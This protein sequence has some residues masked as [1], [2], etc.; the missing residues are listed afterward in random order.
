MFFKRAGRRIYLLI[1]ALSAFAA[2][3]S[4]KSKEQCDARLKQFEQRVEAA[5]VPAPWEN[6]VT[7]YDVPRVPRE[8]AR[9]FET[10]DALIIRTGYGSKRLGGVSGTGKI[11]GFRSASG[12]TL[13]ENIQR[14][15]REVSGRL[16]V[17]IA[18]PN[19]DHDLGDLDQLLRYVD[20]D[21]EFR[22]IV[23]IEGSE[24]P[25][26]PTDAPK[27]VKDRLMK[28]DGPFASERFS[29][30]QKTWE[31]ASERCPGLQ[32]TMKSTL[33]EPDPAAAVS[34]VIPALKQCECNTVDVPALEA[35]V[36]L[37]YFRGGEPELGWVPLE[38]DVVTGTVQDFVSSARRGGTPEAGL[39]GPC[40][41]D[42]DC[43]LPEG[44][45]L[46]FEPSGEV[47]RLGRLS[48]TRPC[49]DGCPTGYR[50]AREPFITGVNA[51]GQ[52]TGYVKEWCGRIQPRVSAT[53]L[54]EIPREV[55]LRYFAGNLSAASSFP[56]LFRGDDGLL[57]VAGS[58]QFQRFKR[59][60]DAYEALSLL[61][62]FN[63]LDGPRSARL[64][65]LLPLTL[66]MIEAAPRDLAP[67]HGMTLRHIVTTDGFEHFSPAG[68]FPDASPVLYWAQGDAILLR[69]DGTRR[70]SSLSAALNE[71]RAE[72]RK[73]VKNPPNA[74]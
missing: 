38:L 15:R 53:P 1:F 72:E 21:V 3:C 2:A 46:G 54:D 35:L 45:C 55:G 47:S 33:I 27:A 31:E 63:P 6:T 52:A 65:E 16:S 36:L 19:R 64:N 5:S 70:F 57:A 23:G 67:E 41:T 74:P 61:I 13:A 30:L 51:S 34:R 7:G 68:R 58:R 66:E 60:A 4:G 56:T 37:Q 39:G 32:E 43:Q 18:V 25:F 71:F 62:G 14:A 24:K 12:S 42:A 10:P 59:D 48:C 20:G 73:G 49:G 44:R 17:Y 26:V 40:Q 22:L 9:P 29:A 69:K 8:R 11:A 50:C 28:L